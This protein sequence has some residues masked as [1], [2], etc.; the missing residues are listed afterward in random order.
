M[1]CRWVYGQLFTLSA[2]LK[3]GSGVA[4]ALAYLH[5]HNICHGDVYAHNILVDRDNHPVIC[6]FGELKCAPATLHRCWQGVEVMLLNEDIASLSLDKDLSMDELSYHKDFQALSISPTI[7]TCASVF[8][9]MLWWSFL[10][11]S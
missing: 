2:L 6:D 5:S 1:V 9:V 11:W 8:S 3:I 7:Y 4:S 10:L